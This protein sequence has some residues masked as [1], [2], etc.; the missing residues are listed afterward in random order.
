[1]SQAEVLLRRLYARCGVS[2]EEVMQ[3]ATS[4]TLGDGSG[5]TLREFIG[6]LFTRGASEVMDITGQP[7]DMRLRSN[8]SGVAV[9]ALQALAGESL[10]PRETV[11]LDAE[12]DPRLAEW[13]EGEMDAL[14]RGLAR[15]AP[16][17][18]IKAAFA[19]GEK[20]PAVAL[21]VA[22]HQS[23]VLARISELLWEK[24]RLPLRM[25]A[26]E[27]WHTGGD[28]AMRA[29]LHALQLGAVAREQADDFPLVPHRL[30]L[31]V[32]P[33]TPLCV[34]LNSSCSGPTPRKIEGLGAAL[35]D[36]TGVCPH[37][38]SATLSL[39]RCDGCG[40]WG[41]AGVPGDAG[42]FRVA[43]HRDELQLPA[44]RFFHAHDIPWHEEAQRQSWHL[45][46]GTAALAPAGLNVSCDSSSRCGRCARALHE[47]A[48]LM[49]SDTGLTL[50]VAAGGVARVSRLSSGLAA[51]AR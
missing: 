14:C 9:G 3:I 26:D 43:T 25:L 2:A 42:R 13:T 32:R 18:G 4:A 10:L 49:Q 30:H 39:F 6:R 23:A 40:E 36:T 27:L 11:S 44:C 21:H 37:C 51:G 48:S 46:A 17:D 45:D 29:T 47:N 15:I 12:G 35:A 16:A 31:L 1:L 38:T 50:S 20:R 19:D 8:N 7:T 22:S 41:I 24:R 33:A 34:C 28:P 5:D